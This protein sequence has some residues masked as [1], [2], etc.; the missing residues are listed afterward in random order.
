MLIQQP[1]LRERILTGLMPAVIAAGIILLIAFSVRW[2]FIGSLDFSAL[3]PYRWALLK[4]LL[5]TLLLTSAAVVIGL[6]AGFLLAVAMRL[7]LLAV[8]IL[9]NAYVEALRNTPLVLQLFWVHYALPYLT[10]YSTTVF[11][12]GLIVMALQ[13]SAYLADV[14]RTGI[15]SIARGQWE[16]AEALSLPWWSKWAEVILP[17]ALK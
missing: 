15:Q 4:G 13:S 3:W 7:P 11:Q 8:R 10:G 1:S 16:A 17:Q 14:A 9:A 2:S 6:P 5:N 12:S